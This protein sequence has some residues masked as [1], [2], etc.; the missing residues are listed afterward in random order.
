M[1][2]EIIFD[3]NRNRKDLYLTT[4]DLRDAFGSV[5]HDYIMYMLQ[6]MNFPEEIG[7]IIEDSYKNGTTR[8]HVGSNCSE[9][10][11][12]HKGVKQG[13]PL[14]PLIFN[15]C[16]NPLLKA[17]DELG[18]G[19]NIENDDNR[20]QR[21]SIGT[22]VSIQA[23]A[24]DIVLFSST[25]EGMLRNIATLETFLQY[26]K[27][28]VNAEKCHS[29]SYIIDNGKRVFDDEPLQIGGEDIP[30]ATF[31]ESVEY[32]GT[33]TATTNTIRRK[34]AFEAVRE[35]ENLI[36][37]IGNSVLTLNQ[38]IYAIKTFAIP[39]LDFL[40]TN[41]RIALNDMKQLDKLIRSTI[42][43]H[44]QGVH[45][46]KHLFYT[47]WKDGGFSIQPLHERALALR[48]KSFMAL[49]NSKNEKVHNAMKHFVNSERR[50]RNIGTL[51]DDDAAAFLNWNIE[52]K[53]NKGTDT[54]VFKALR[55][56]QKLGFTF[57]VNEDMDNIV[58]IFNNN[59]T[60]NDISPDNNRTNN[61]NNN[62][63]TRTDGDNNNNS[64]NDVNIPTEIT[65]E[66]ST[67]I[68]TLTSAKTLVQHVMKGIRMK[69]REELIENE[70]IGHSFIN[71]KNCGYANKFIGDYSHP[72]NDKIAS[73]IIKAR[74]NMVMTGSKGIQ[75]K[76]SEDRSPHCPYCGATKQDTLSHRINGC[77]YN[78]HEQTKR[79]N[80]IQNI[81]MKYMKNRLDKNLRYKTNCTVNIEGNHVSEDYSRL[82][83]DI[84]AWNNEEIIIAEFSCPYDNITNGDDKMKRVYEEKIEKYRELVAECRRVYNRKV[85]LYT[86]IVSSLGAIYKKSVSDLHKLLKIR[87]QEKRLMNVITRRISM[88]ACI[89]SYFIFN[90]MKFKAFT[91]DVED[92]T[93]EEEGHEVEEITNTDINQISNGKI[94]D[95]EEADDEQWSGDDSQVQKS[96]NTEQ[97]DSSDD[98]G[99]SIE[100]EEES[101]EGII[102]QKDVKMDE[103]EDDSDG[104]DELYSGV[105]AVVDASNE[106]DDDDEDGAEDS[107]RCEDY[108]GTTCE[109]G[110]TPE[111]Q[112]MAPNKA[113]ASSDESSE[114]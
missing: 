106:D 7:M 79:H 57:K 103:I 45:L 62:T 96:D 48:A 31:A 63:N 101:D 46:P 33:D 32:L 53:V 55:A 22:K 86:I 43:K 69:H 108:A 40:L 113:S 29:I 88:A 34:G 97:D 65:G 26:S 105:N 14:S 93:N 25:R 78:R 8:V 89:G 77:K 109:D 70:G 2:S 54:I 83:P 81:I 74:C 17:I 50:Y 1:I 92:A 9:S 28:N 27:V 42:N 49:Y 95:D 60:Q 76:L 85:S 4:I 6:Q 66:E 15:F 100:E 110:N 12:I 47:H 87:K 75:M 68:L 94:G 99:C 21:N 11:D 71:I 102:T 112:A 13:C 84:L 56:S 5:P 39:K 20:Q 91:V 67:S 41:G 37:K 36:N 16:M 80:N 23:Y 3:A 18:E 107:R 52:D 30:I 19:Y 90:R 82:K 38:K 58:A 111:G 44:V 51:E 10:I 73:W 104:D 61:G 24:D 98:D 59:P 64:D 72:L 35:T 114:F